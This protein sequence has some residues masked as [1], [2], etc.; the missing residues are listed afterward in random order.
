VACERSAGSA[1][2]RRRLTENRQPIRPDIRITTNAAAAV[3]KD[4]GRSPGKGAAR[5][6]QSKRRIYA[7]RTEKSTTKSID[8]IN[9]KKVKASPTTKNQ[10]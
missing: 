8:Y 3:P 4:L 2:V 10:G 9:H 5:V 7:R 6:N 1:R